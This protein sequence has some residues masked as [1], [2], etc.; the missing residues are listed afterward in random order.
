MK[1]VVLRI[2]LFYVSNICL[3]RKVNF[4]LEW[5]ILSLNYHH[6][7][8]FYVIFVFYFKKLK[9]ILM[10]FK[11]LI[12]FCSVRV[13]QWFYCTNNFA[14]NVCVFFFTFT[15]NKILYIEKKMQEKLFKMRILLIY[16]AKTVRKSCNLVENQQFLQKKKSSTRFYIIFVL[17]VLIKFSFFPCFHFLC[18]NNLISLWI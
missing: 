12:D 1:S 6:F 18:I 10:K 11:E 2:L 3:K 15:K 4:E 16:F 13:A 14:L 9:N 8:T 17:I 7:R 5:Q